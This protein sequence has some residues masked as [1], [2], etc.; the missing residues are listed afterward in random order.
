MVPEE[1]CAMAEKREAAAAIGVFLRGTQVETVPEELAHETIRIN[2]TGDRFENLCSRDEL[3]VDEI[4]LKVGPTYLHYHLMQ[5]K[6][7]W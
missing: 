3:E 4:H 7:Y 1:G 5:I 2:R 6:N